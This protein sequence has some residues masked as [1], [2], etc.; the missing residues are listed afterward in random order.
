M[1]IF[2]VQSHIGGGGAERVGVLLA[3]GLAQRGHEVSL[4]TNL[5]DEVKYPVDERVKVL[6]MVSSNGHKLRK[7][8]SA[9]RNLRKLVKEYHPDVIIGIM[10]L[11]SLISRIACLGTKTPIIMTEHDSFERPP[12]A[13]M[14]KME[15]FCKFY[16]NKIYECVTVITQADKDFIGK[17]LKK[18]QVMPNP[19]LLQP[20]KEIPQKEKVI[21]AA[22][23][24]D[25]WH[26]KGLDVLI[27][28]WGKVVESRES[29]VERKGWRLQIAGTGSEESLQY[30]KSL[31]KENGVED[32]VDFLGFVSDMESLYKKA[33][34]FVLSSRYEGFGLVLIEAMSQGCAC[35]ACD[36][37]GRQREIMETLPGP[38]CLG[39]GAE[40][41][42]AKR[43][44]F[45]ENSTGILCPPD[46]VE[47][48]AAALKKMV[49]DDDY[50]ES[51]RQ[52]AIE[53]ADYYNIDNIASQWEILFR[54][55]LN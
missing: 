10:Q 35:I 5:H 45:F 28:A 30:L 12:S 13:P 21:L 27:K 11:S 42:N 51:V 3:D 32:S 37:K 1:K 46:D 18:V 48:L 50:R 19:L 24:L 2:I 15:Y 53:R 44:P 40:V 17:R 34:V 55:M 7:W 9:T 33:S 26:Y 47:A 54:Q 6:N 52:S 31:C 39:R 14:S 8:L 41:Q 4:V 20:V 38:P 25:A 22:G 49:E 16:L 43:D 23:R 29:R 36:Y